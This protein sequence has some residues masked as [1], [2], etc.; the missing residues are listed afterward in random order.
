MSTSLTRIDPAS[1]DEGAAEYQDRSLFTRSRSRTGREFEMGRVDARKTQPHEVVGPSF[2][3]RQNDIVGKDRIDEDVRVWNGGCG[4]IEEGRPGPD[5]L[6][7]GTVVLFHIDDA[8]VDMLVVVL[9]RGQASLVSFGR[10]KVVR[11]VETEI[12]QGRSLQT[13]DKGDSARRV[14]GS[15]ARQVA[16]RA[17][18]SKLTKVPRRRDGEVLGPPGSTDV[19]PI[20]RQ[21][22]TGFEVDR[23]GSGDE[24][25]ALPGDVQGS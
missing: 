15:R 8:E 18:Q 10:P 5:E 12:E 17:G 11:E 22:L 21:A 20:T 24:G 6:A 13:G 25:S 1:G 16:C 2:R 4:Q 7:D 23:L 19:L 9:E 3:D 14:D